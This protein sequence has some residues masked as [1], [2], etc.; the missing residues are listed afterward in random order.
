M[1]CRLSPVVPAQLCEE[2]AYKFSKRRVTVAS[3][4]LGQKHNCVSVF[5][6]AVFSRLT[7]ICFL[8]VDSYMFFEGSTPYR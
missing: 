8:E 7:P 3:T 5:F 2:L 4:R 6:V 1:S